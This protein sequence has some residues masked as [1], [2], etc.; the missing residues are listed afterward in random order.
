MPNLL[1]FGDSWASSADMIETWPELLGRR[2]GWRIVNLATPYS[3]STGLQEQL[4]E[5]CRVV[6]YRPNQPLTDDDLAIV[7]TGGNDLYHSGGLAL[8]AIALSG[9]CAGWYAPSA[10]RGISANMQLL[11][12]GLITLG[13]RRV[14]LAGVP[15]S[16]KM[17]FLAKP[18]TASAP[19]AL[20]FATCVLRGCNATL[21]AAMQTALS[22]AE[23]TSGIA[24]H[25]GTTLDEALALDGILELP[26]PPGEDWWEDVSHPSQALHGA[27]AEAL[28]SKLKKA[29]DTPRMSPNLRRKAP[30]ESEVQLSLLSTPAEREA[31]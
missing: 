8:G 4:L 29:M 2:W 15:L 19:W 16:T 13:V 27:L 1:F 11:V 20:S 26:P 30:E 17:P 18:I 3:G 12:E 25:L 24:L 31:M 5:L 9:A 28:Q 21:L 23:R 14:V 7:H 10:A 6:K 22:E